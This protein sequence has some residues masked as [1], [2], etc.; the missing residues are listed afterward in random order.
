M[1]RTGQQR[2]PTGE[3]FAALIA[4]IGKRRDREAFAT[5]FAHYAPRVKSYMMRLG[6]PAEA[7]EELAQEA[8]L[9]VWRRAAI[10]DPERAAPSTWI[11]TIARNLRIDRARREGRSTPAPDPTDD[12]VEG[13]AAP[14]MLVAGA[15]TGARISRAIAELPADQARVIRLAFFSDRPHSQI[16]QDLELPLGTVKSRLRL[17]MS[18]LR[19]ALED[20]R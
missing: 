2:P 1:N 14:D 13:P 9:T 15:Q 3:D 5:L 16:A 17:A 20:I 6:A 18:R 19:A 4:A 11:F 8:M 10:F 12:A 7:A